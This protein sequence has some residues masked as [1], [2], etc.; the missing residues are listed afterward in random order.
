MKC[1]LWGT[2]LVVISLNFTLHT[3]IYVSS[4][5][6]LIFFSRGDKTHLHTNRALIFSYCKVVPILSV[7]QCV[8]EHQAGRRTAC[9]GCRKCPALSGAP[10][11]PSRPSCC[12][13]LLRCLT[14]PLLLAQLDLL[15]SCHVSLVSLGRISQCKV[16]LYCMQ[17][18]C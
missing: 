4:F 10:T 7:G 1:Q 9:G 16:Q 17:G 3:I 13:V 8:L 14:P 5:P 6:I 2:L 15:H 12:A 18:M 11:T